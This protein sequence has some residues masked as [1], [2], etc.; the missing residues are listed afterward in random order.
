V[1]TARHQRASWRS[2]VTNR[3]FV[4]HYLQMLAAMLAGMVVLGPLSMLLGDGA[5]A[6]VE[7]LLMG[8]LDDRRD[9]GLDGV[10]APSLAGDRRDGPGHVPRLRGA[11]PPALARQLSMDGLI[12]LG[13][14]LMLPAMVIAMLRRREEDLV[15]HRSHP[16]P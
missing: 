11:V 14:V 3:A 4:V 7:A 15:A 6:E 9:G 12:L 13:H 5:S 1:T 2:A 8:Q 10:A 16:T